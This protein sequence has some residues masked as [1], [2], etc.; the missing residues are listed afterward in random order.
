MSK[1]NGI[2][3]R[4][5][6]DPVDKTHGIFAQMLWRIQCQGE[7]LLN[8]SALA[9]TR[10]NKS[11]SSIA[12]ITVSEGPHYQV[13]RKKI[14]WVKIRTDCVLHIAPAGRNVPCMRQAL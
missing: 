4:R 1:V 14:E 3:I 7:L 12:Y 13:P 11:I 6:I 8:T 5:K 2:S 9:S 10:K